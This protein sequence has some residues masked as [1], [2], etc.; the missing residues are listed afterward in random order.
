M[1][2][3]T[4]LSTPCQHLSRPDIIEYWNSTNVPSDLEG[5]MG[6]EKWRVWMAIET[7]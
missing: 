1:I 7:V 3:S 5:G 4:S 6:T 2:T